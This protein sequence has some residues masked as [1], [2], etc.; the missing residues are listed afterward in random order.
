MCAAKKLRQKAFMVLEVCDERGEL[1]FA[2]A[3]EA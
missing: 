3:R 1:D 2:A